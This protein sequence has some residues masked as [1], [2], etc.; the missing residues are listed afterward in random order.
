[1]PILP[2]KK[3]GLISCSGEELP[4]GTLSR[5]ATLRVL[6]QL[7]PNDTVTL[8]LPLFLAGDDKERAF[9]KF[10]PTIAIDGCDKRCAARATEKYSAK[11]T[12]SIVIPEFLATRGLGAPKTRRQMDA[13]DERATDALAEEIA[14]RV[15][16]ILGVNHAVV[17]G[18]PV[19]ESEA[20]IASCSCGSGVPVMR[21]DIAGKQVQVIALPLIFEE[22]RKNDKSSEQVFET[23]KVYNVIPIELES[24][25]REAILCAYAEFVPGLEKREE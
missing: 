10:Y 21:L 9:A 19:T 13:T 25:Y 24:A 15:D 22:G 14:Q 8:C 5:V 4:E 2:K 18:A 6:E 23:V 3:V 11:P 12:A 17:M 20:V 16:E 1:M 7:R